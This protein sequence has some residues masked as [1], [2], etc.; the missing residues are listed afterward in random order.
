MAVW[1]YRGELIPELWLIAKHGKIPEALD[2]YITTEDTNLDA[3]EDSH[4]WRDIDVPDD[5]LQ[6]VSA[7]MPQ[8]TS[9][10][11]DAFMF[12]D[13]QTSDFEIW[14]DQGEVDAI[15][16]RWD[17]REPDLEVLNQMISLA[18]SLG[19]HIVSGDR[20]TVIEPDF[21]AVLNDVQKSNAYRFCKDPKAFLTELGR[22]NDEE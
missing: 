22:K 5:L 1:Q 9:W 4:C 14:Y 19:A 13:D 3:I 10:T 7:I 2:N 15:Y 21:Y 8:R 11:N 16:F 6:R 12:G 18:K 20:A 17:L